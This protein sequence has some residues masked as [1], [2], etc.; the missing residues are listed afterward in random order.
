MN[1]AQIPQ[2]FRD[3]VLLIGRGKET[4]WLP[5]VAH[6]VGFTDAFSAEKYRAEMEK[7]TNGRGEALCVLE[8]FEETT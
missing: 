3:R 5:G 6:A 8:F 2:R 7:E 4:L 1:E